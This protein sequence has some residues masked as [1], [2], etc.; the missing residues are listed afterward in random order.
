MKKIAITL[1]AAVVAFC[2]TQEA[3][4]QGVAI[5]SKPTCVPYNW[6]NMNYE[7]DEPEFKIKLLTIEAINSGI[8]VF[9]SEGADSKYGSVTLVYYDSKRKCILWM[10]SMSLQDFAYRV[11]L[12]PV[13]ISPFYEETK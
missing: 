3:Q 1:A 9:R 2:V 10:E 7:I 4:S 6:V 11:G 5:S 13:G 12:N 8:R